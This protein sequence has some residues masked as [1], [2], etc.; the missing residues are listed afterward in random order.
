MHVDVGVAFLERVEARQQP[1]RREGRRNADREQS[2]FTQRIDGIH[3]GRKTGKTFLQ[4]AEAGG[5][6]IGEHKAAAIAGEDRQA[7]VIFQQADLVTD[8]SRR[9]VQLL[10]RQRD[11]EVAARAFKGAQCIQRG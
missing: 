10:C 8:G 9:D 2:R 4:I 3:R 1:L 6:G 11:A 7:D 5:T